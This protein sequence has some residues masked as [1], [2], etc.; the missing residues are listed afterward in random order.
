M[1]LTILRFEILE[2]RN[3][4]NK[5]KETLERFLIKNIYIY[6]KVSYS[7]ETYPSSP[8]IHPNGKGDE[9]ERARKREGV[10]SIIEPSGPK[11]KK[12]S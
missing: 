12:S 1:K 3:L 10:I 8:N 6:I 5:V 11:K 9:G 7:Y 4:Q 2:H